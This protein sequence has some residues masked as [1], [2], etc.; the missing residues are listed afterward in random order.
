MACNLL[1]IFNCKKINSKAFLI[2]VDYNYYSSFTFLYSKMTEQNMMDF[3][4]FKIATYKV[5]QTI[6]FDSIV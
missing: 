4:A 1:S 6:S 3:S 5:N 2:P